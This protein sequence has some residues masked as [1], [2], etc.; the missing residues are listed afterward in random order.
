MNKSIWQIP[1]FFLYI[2]CNFPSGPCVL[3]IAYACGIQHSFGGQNGWGACI[4]VAVI[5]QGLDSRLDDC[6]GTFIA[7][8]K[9]HIHLGSFKAAAPVI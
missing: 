7:R 1:N 3:V 9:S 5:D 4:F 8:E 2:Q 6:L